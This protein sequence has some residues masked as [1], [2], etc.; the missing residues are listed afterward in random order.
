MSL[1]VLPFTKMD[2]PGEAPRSEPLACLLT[3]WTDFPATIMQA[4][5]ERRWA[6][7]ISGL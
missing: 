1:I 5:G 4:I 7:E 2:C 3:V 6:K